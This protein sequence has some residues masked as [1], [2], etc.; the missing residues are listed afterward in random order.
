MADSRPFPCK[1]VEPSPRATRL[2]YM[3]RILVSIHFSEI[4]KFRSAA[5]LMGPYTSLKP[6]RI[7][8]KLHASVKL[9]PM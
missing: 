2:V 5:N 1:Y 3:L 7:R 4:L 6:S 8:F 9:S